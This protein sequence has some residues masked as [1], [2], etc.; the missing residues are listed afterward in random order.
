[1]ISDNNRCYLRFLCEIT[2]AEAVNQL[3][4]LGYEKSLAE[5][6]IFIALGGDDVVEDVAQRIENIRASRQK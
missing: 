3:V 2:A 4:A 5:E 6:Q 1:M